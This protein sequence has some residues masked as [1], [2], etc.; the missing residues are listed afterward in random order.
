MVYYT[1]SHD[2]IRK[3]AGADQASWKQY[4]ATGK[5]QK[6]G[7]GGEG[8]AGMGGRNVDIVC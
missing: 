8:G 6:K 7:V 3:W 5:C 1:Y 2:F 4:D